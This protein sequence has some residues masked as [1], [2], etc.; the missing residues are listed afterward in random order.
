MERLKRKLSSP[1]PLTIYGNDWARQLVLLAEKC[2]SLQEFANGFGY[3]FKE[4]IEPN[5]FDLNRLISQMKVFQTN[6]TL[7][8]KLFS[9]FQLATKIPS[10]FAKPLEELVAHN[11]LGPIVFCTPE[12]GKWT[13]TGGLGVMVDELTQELA[14][15]NEDVYIIT[16]YYH[17]NKKGETD[18][19]A[20]DG[21]TH[22]R[23][24]EIWVNSC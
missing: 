17:R 16:P 19:L 6:K 18:Y 4:V 9:F 22:L 23:N 21:F 1:I 11:K 20:S 5:N 8:C 15:M 3:F 13:T 10:S 12:L 24:I 7:L 14:K 2:N